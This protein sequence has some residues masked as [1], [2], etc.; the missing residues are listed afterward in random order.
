MLYNGNGS[1]KTGFCF[2][3]QKIDIVFQEDENRLIKREFQKCLIK[4]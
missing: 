2:G 4:L 3:D 1:G